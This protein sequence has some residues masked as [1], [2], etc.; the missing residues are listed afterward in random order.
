VKVY[1][2]IALVCRTLSAYLFGALGKTNAWA[3]FPRGF[4]ISC[5]EF[6]GM[7]LVNP[8]NRRGF[9]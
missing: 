8:V 2:K 6:Y 7:R 4:Q 5:V 1:L 3:R 9:S